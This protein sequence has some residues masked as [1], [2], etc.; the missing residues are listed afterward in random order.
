MGLIPKD[1]SQPIDI[2]Q[3]CQQVT[4][5]TENVYETIADET[6]MFATY[7]P[8]KDIDIMIKHV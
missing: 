4:E 7:L 8:D 6:Y 5:H 2:E 1:S 3:Y